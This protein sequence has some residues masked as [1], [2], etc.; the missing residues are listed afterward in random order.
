M[1][2]TDRRARP[3]PAAAAGEWFAAYDWS[4]LRID[5]PWRFGFSGGMARFAAIDPL[6]FHLV[7]PSS[8]LANLVVVPI[9]FFILAVA[10]LSLV[11]APMASGLSL[12]STT[13]TGRSPAR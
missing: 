11:A 9:A 4:R 7:T 6:V 8:L 13:R 2:S 12:I 10:L 3:I 5:L 1:A